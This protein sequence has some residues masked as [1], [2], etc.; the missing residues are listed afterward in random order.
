MKRTITQLNSDIDY[1]RERLVNDFEDEEAK[2]ELE[3]C[4][5]ESKSYDAPVQELFWEVAR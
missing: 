5:A 2:E 4:M 1:Y 3:K